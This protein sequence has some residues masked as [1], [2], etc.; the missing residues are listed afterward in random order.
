MLP[1]VQIFANALSPDVSCKKD[2]LFPNLMSFVR[3]AFAL[4]FI[5]GIGCTLREASEA[6]HS[7]LEQRGPF[8]AGKRF[9]LP[10]LRISTVAQKENEIYCVASVFS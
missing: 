4:F 2:C 7:G 6:E 1:F 10:V 5:A 8:P 3:R 9:L